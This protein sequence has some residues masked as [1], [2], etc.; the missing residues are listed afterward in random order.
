M[1]DRGKGMGQYEISGV[2]MRQDC[3]SATQD[4]VVGM[5]RQLGSQG[6]RTR[7]LVALSAGHV[8]R[9]QSPTISGD[10]GQEQAGVSIAELELLGALHKET[11]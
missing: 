5:E 8:G 7:C 11:T 6:G 4:K 10:C 3:T 1:K 9:S 2:W